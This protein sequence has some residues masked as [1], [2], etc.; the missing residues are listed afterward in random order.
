M[1]M[2][3]ASLPRTTFLLHRG[4]FDRPGEQVVAGT[5]AVLPEFPAEDFPRNRL[6]LAQ[7]LVKPTHPLT[8]RVMVNRLWQTFFGVGLVRTP[9][10]FGVRGEPPTHPELLDWLA[11]E[12]VES[13]WDVKHIVRLMVTSST[14]RQ[15]SRVEREFL[16][17][18]TDNRWLAR[19]PRLRMEAETLRDSLLFVSGLLDQ[20]IG[21]PSVFPYQPP[22]L[23]EEV[24]FNPNDFSAQVYFQSR[25][26]DL[27]RRGLYT[28]WKRTL[29]PPAM[30]IFDAPTRETC[31][32]SRGRSNTALQALVLMNDP[33]A[34]EAARYLA[35]RGM[36]E[37]GSSAESTAAFLFQVAT[38][39]PPTVGERNELVGLFERQVA[40]FQRDPEAATQLLA[41][42][43]SPR[44]QRLDPIPHAAWTVVAN[45]ILSLDEFITRN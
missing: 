43:D 33:T 8:A 2:R 29:P 9:E 12:L 35:A 24:S 32:A 25:G 20:R 26:A 14:Y 6:G 38:S 28:F 22:G 16:D 17:R 45:T 23:W 1:V 31:V 13:G 3:E 27:Y 37:Q 30:V 18:D 11:V 39:R 44:D 15:S 4:K 40:R 19:A 42:G 36:L 7:W 5:P 34:I 10:D 21:G 41:T